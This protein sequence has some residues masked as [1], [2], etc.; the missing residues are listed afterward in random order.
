MVA[1]SRGGGRSTASDDESRSE[2]V[3][4]DNVEGHRSGALHHD[5]KAVSGAGDEHRRAAE[6]VVAGQDSSV[7]ELCQGTW[8]RRD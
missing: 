6:V 1:D 7:A 4:G 5:A 8:K 2:A 3:I